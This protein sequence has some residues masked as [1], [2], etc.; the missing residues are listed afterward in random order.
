[1][2]LDPTLIPIERKRE[3]GLWP[4]EGL[5][6]FGAIPYLRKISSRTGIISN[7][8]LG[9]SAYVILEEFSDAT[10]Y[11]D[12]GG[13]EASVARN[14]LDAIPA[15]RVNYLGPDDGFVGADFLLVEN[16][17][18][19]YYVLKR[20]YDQVRSGGYVFVDHE[21]DQERIK[22]IKQFRTEN[23]ITTPVQMSKNFMWFWQKR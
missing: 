10:L 15:G 22:F 2:L 12:V 9:E 17:I 5:A 13:D 16:S 7:A 18:A 20:F 6:A 8:G 21:N 14:N 4:N 11:L 3:L 19:P 23:R 1:M